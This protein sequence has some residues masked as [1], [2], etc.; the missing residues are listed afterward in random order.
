LG[1]SALEQVGGEF[2]EAVVVAGAEDFFKILFFLFF[3]CHLGEKFDISWFFVV[4]VSN[5]LLIPLIFG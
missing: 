1:K 3:K 5:L 2:A 4:F